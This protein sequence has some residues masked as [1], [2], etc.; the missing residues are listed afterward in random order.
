MKLLAN[1]CCLYDKRTRYALYLSYL[2]VNHEIA[3]IKT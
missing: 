2:K 1:H 3:K